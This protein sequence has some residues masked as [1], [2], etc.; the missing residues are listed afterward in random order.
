MYLLLNKRKTKFLDDKIITLTKAC[1]AATIKIN[2]Y[3]KWRSAPP[4]HI[5]DSPGHLFILCCT[6]I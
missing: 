1:F 3:E 6:L 4:P 2:L 5:L